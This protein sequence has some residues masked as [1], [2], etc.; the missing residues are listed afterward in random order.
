MCGLFALDL[1]SHGIRIAAGGS[2][3]APSIMEVNG[4]H[5]LRWTYEI[6]QGAC[7]GHV[8]GQHDTGELGARLLRDAELCAPAEQQPGDNP[9]LARDGR[10]LGARQLSFPGD[11]EFLF[12]AEE[13]PGRRFGRG[14]IA[15]FGGCQAGSGCEFLAL[16]LTAG[17]AEG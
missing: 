6:A 15:D 10:D 14:W 7:S 17:R 3:D 12:V 16:V 1:R 9:M 8:V 4:H 2:E 5:A 13:A 11:R